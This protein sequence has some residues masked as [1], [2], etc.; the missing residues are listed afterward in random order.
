MVGAQGVVIQENFL[1][2]FDYC[3]MIMISLNLVIHVYHSD[4]YSLCGESQRRKGGVSQQL[5]Q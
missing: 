2:V 3:H 4:V 1:S 5:F